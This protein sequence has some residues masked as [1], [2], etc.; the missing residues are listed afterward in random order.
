MGAKSLTEET[1]FFDNDCISAFLWIDDTSIVTKLYAKRIAIPKQVYNE[2]SV[3]RGAAQVLKTRIDLMIKNGDVICI[4]MDTDSAE[5]SLFSELAVCSS[6]GERLIGRG[7]AACIALA[8]E[9]NGILA[10]NNFKDI[11]KYIERYNLKHTTTADIIVEA[12]DKNI[13]SSEQA[14]Q[15]WKDMRSKRRNIGAES[16][17][18]YLVLIGR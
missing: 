11:K 16:F 6:N 15:M 9:R 8:K 7:E 4:D 3:C 5:Y 2:L 12:Y 17:E 13:I 10:S 18:D 14:E 1:L